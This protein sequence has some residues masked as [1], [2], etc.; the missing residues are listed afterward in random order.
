MG[1][2]DDAAGK[3]HVKVL[4]L[5]EPRESADLKDTS[6]GFEVD[7]R[8]RRRKRFGDCKIAADVLETGLP[9]SHRASDGAYQDFSLGSLNRSGPGYA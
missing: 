2:D 1:R 7:Y 8:P 5:L 9:V 4:H 6:Q 3:D